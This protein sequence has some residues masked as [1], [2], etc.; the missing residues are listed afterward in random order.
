MTNDV[1]LQKRTRCL[2]QRA[3][4]LFNN[5]IRQPDVGFPLWHGQVDRLV[6]VQASRP[7]WFIKR[8]INYVQNYLSRELNLEVQG[9]PGQRG[10][11]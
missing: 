10:R 3:Q 2:P 11:G 9:L 7:E 5:S 6:Q 8:H 1:D 4:R